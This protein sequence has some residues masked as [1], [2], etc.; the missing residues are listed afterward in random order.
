MFGIALI[1]FSLWYSYLFRNQQFFKEL[2]GIPAAYGEINPLAV[3]NDAGKN[4]PPCYRIQFKNDSSIFVLRMYGE[5]FDFKKMNEEMARRDSIKILYHPMKNEYGQ[6]EIC[7][8]NRGETEIYKFNKN[9]NQTSSGIFGWILCVAGIVV[10]V[11]GIFSLR[12]RLK[13][14][15][16]VS[17]EF[18]D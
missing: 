14:D 5:S 18:E 9:F 8:I 13:K 6:F 1:V 4:S 16:G 7:S 12:M 10:F 11:S 2:S 15:Y 3:F 17:K